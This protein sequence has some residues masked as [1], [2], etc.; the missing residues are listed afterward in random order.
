M[1]IGCRDFEMFKRT[2]EILYISSG[3]LNVYI[4]EETRKDLLEN[5]GV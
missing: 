3:H 1:D 2:L 4:N 5:N